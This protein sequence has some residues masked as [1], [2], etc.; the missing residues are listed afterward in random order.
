[1]K[2][3]V[4][5]QLDGQSPNGA[6][7][8]NPETPHTDIDPRVP[9]VQS[10]QDGEIAVGRGYTDRSSDIEAYEVSDEDE[11]DLLWRLERSEGGLGG[12]GGSGS[13]DIS[14][15]F[16]EQWVGLDIVGGDSDDDNK[17]VG[18]KFSTLTSEVDDWDRVEEGALGE[19]GLE[20][21]L[22]RN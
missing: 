4:S 1:M 21:A 8:S 15:S 18:G 16:D 3:H 2:H 19:G 7:I 11:D 13:D 5:Q 6:D 20:G 17:Y 14:D 22:K 10:V 12:L 9:A